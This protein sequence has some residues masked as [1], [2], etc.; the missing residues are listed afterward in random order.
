MRVP[1]SAPICAKR[2]SL[3]NH[4]NSVQ[5]P[6][7]TQLEF[8]ISIAT[9]DKYKQN[10]SVLKGCIGPLI[11]N[12]NLLSEDFGVFPQERKLERML[13]RLVSS[14]MRGGNPHDLAKWLT[15]FWGHTGQSKRKDQA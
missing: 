9:V 14:K 6:K 5:N 15:A 3:Q 1:Y 4:Q 10:S 8:D 2:P 7:I 13:P 12:T 11:S